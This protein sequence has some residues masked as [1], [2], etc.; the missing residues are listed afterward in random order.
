MRCLDLNLRVIEVEPR[1]PYQNDDSVKA[2]EMFHNGVTKYACFD[3]NGKG[4][5][6]KILK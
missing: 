1:H 2:Y 6:L 3:E 5:D 4:I